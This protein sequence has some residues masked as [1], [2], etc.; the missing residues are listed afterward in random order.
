M[1]G[2]LAAFAEETK[3]EGAVPGKSVCNGKK[4]VVM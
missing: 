3:E 2:A 1:R 4:A